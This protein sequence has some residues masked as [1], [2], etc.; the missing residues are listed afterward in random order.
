MSEEI[1]FPLFHR[2]SR[3]IELTEP[4]RTFL[5]ETRC[6]VGDVL[7]LSDTARRLRAAPS[8]TLTIGMVLTWLT[9][10]VMALLAAGVVLGSVSAKVV[11][12][13]PCDVLVVR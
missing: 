1:G 12:D 3:G 6:V 9:I 2:T 13:A 11:R 10:A 7:S 8:D 5:Y 4:G